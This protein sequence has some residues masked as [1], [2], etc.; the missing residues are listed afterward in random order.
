M[1]ELKIYG[2]LVNKKDGI[3]A[4]ANQIAFDD[5]EKLDVKFDELNGK[6]TTL[7]EKVDSIAGGTVDVDAINKNIDDLKSR[8]GVNESDIANL[9]KQNE[10]QE[11]KLDETSSKAD[12][13]ASKIASLQSADALL[14]SKMDSVT[15]NNQAAIDA[16]DSKI[17]KVEDS[18]LIL[19]K[20]S[21]NKANIDTLYDTGIY[22]LTNA[23]NSPSESADGVLTVTSTGEN[24]IKQLWDTKKLSAVRLGSIVT[25]ETEKQ[26]EFSVIENGSELKY[27]STNCE[28][29]LT[30]GKTYTLSGFL[31]GHIV[32]N[33]GSTAP[34]NSTK[35]ILNGVHIESDIESAIHYAVNSSRLILELPYGTTNYVS[36]YPDA[37]GS[38]TDYSATIY[39]ENN[40]TVEGAGSLI[41]RNNWSQSHGIKGSEV[42]IVL[43]PKVNPGLEISSNHDGIHG[44]SLVD[45]A[46]GNIYIHDVTN[47]GIE[48]QNSDSTKGDLRIRA[49]KIKIANAKFGIDG[50]ISCRVEGL[51]TSLE[52]SSVKEPV[53]EKYLSQAHILD[54][55]KITGA[56]LATE[57]KLTFFGEPKVWIGDSLGNKL[58]DITADSGIYS[59]VNAGEDG[60]VY[61][62]GYIKDCKIVCANK[63]ANLVLKNCYIENTTDST[64]ISY[65]NA[66]SRLAIKSIGNDD[67]TYVTNYIV[68]SSSE[69]VIT[70][71]NNGAINTHKPLFIKGAGQLFTASE[72]TIRGDGDKYF[73]GDDATA[74]H[75]QGTYVYIGADADDV[76]TGTAGNADQNIFG[77]KI[78]AR[79]SS[80]LEKGTIFTYSQ[81]KGNIYADEISGES[82]TAPFNLD[83]TPAG[84]I[85]VAENSSISYPDYYIQVSASMKDVDV[86]FPSKENVAKQ[87]TGDWT[88]LKDASEFPTTDSITELIKNNSIRSYPSIED[89][90]AEI[91]NLSVASIVAIKVDST[92]EY[93]TNYE[94]YIVVEDSDGNKVFK[95]LKGSGSDGGTTN[96]VTLTIDDLYIDGVRQN[97]S[98]A[99][100]EANI[101]SKIDIKYSFVSMYHDDVKG[102]VYFK[103]G[104]TLANQER[105]LPTDGQVNSW[106]YDTSGLTAGT[107]KFSIYGS[108]VTGTTSPRQTL[109]FEIGGLNIT[110][111]FNEENVLTAGNNIQ[112]PVSIT[113]ATPNAAITAHVLVDGSEVKTESVKTSTTSLLIPGSYITAGTHEIEI[114]LTNDKSKE[115]NHISY[116][117]IAANMG[118]IYVLSDK[119]VYSISAGSRLDVQIR[120]IQMGQEKGSFSAKMKITDVN[121]DLVELNGK[122][123]SSYTFNYGKNTLQI[124]GLPYKQNDSGSTDSD[125]T[126]YTIALTV[127]SEDPDA[128]AVTKS[129]EARV[130]QNDYNISASTD[131]LL[132]WFDAAGKSNKDDDKDTWLD[133]SGNGV[134]ATFGNFNW[135]SN[136]WLQDENGNTALTLNSG[137]YVELDITPFEDEPNELTISIDYETTDI[138][139]SSAKVVSCLRETASKD[140]VTYYLRDSWGDYVKNDTNVAGT[141]LDTSFNDLTVLEDRTGAIAFILSTITNA[142][143]K[144]AKKTELEGMT[145]DE[146]LEEY[147]TKKFSYVNNIL[148]Y[149]MFAGGYCWIDGK[150]YV[151]DGKTPYDV[152]YAQSE[153][154]INFNKGDDDSEYDADNGHYAKKTGKTSEDVT[155]QQGF[156]IDTQYGV[157]SNSSSKADAEDKFHM[158][159][160]QG[161]R[162]R[163]DFIITRNGAVKPYFLSCMAGYVNGVITGIQEIT[164]QDT[165]KQVDSKGKKYRVYLG[166]K[167]T[168]DDNGNLTVS[169]TGSCKIYSFRIYNKALDHSQILYNYAAE[170]PDYDEKVKV[171]DNNGLVNSTSLAHLPRLCLMGAKVNGRSTIRDF[172]MQLANSDESQIS[173]LKSMKEPAY[174]T[175]TDPDNTDNNWL[176]DDGTFVIPVRLQFQGTSSMVYPMKNYKFKMY[177]SM[178]ISSDG[179][180]TYGK[181]LKKD[182]VGAGINEST[183]TIKVNYM[184]S[185]NVRNTGSANFI[186][187]YN[188]ITG[189]TPAM[190]IDSRTRTT[191]YGYPILLYYKESPDSTDEEQFLGVGCLNLD[192]SD[193]D[194]FGLDK[195]IND[196]DNVEYDF[197]KAFFIDDDFSKDILT[198]KTKSDGT[199]ETISL[200]DSDEG[201]FKDYTALFNKDGLL[202]A[203]VSSK[204]YLRSVSNQKVSNTACF[205]LK[206]NSGAS[207][208]GGFGNYYIDSVASDVEPRY[209]DDGDIEDDE[210]TPYAQDIAKDLADRTLNKTS[211]SALTFKQ[212][213]SPYFYHFQR[214]IKW[215]RSAS[216]EE[217]VSNIDK[218]FNRNYLMDYYLT[219]LLLGGVDSLGKNLMVGTWGPENRLFLTNED[220]A[221]DPL[222]FDYTLA[223][224]TIIRIT[225]KKNKSTGAYAF[226]EDEN[227]RQLFYDE[228]CYSR[229][230]KQF[231]SGYSA[232]VVTTTP[233]ECIWYPMFYDIDTILGV[234]NSGQLLYD[235]DIELGDQ[236]EDGTMVFNTADSYLWTKVKNYLGDKDSSGNSL[237]SDRWS[238]LTNAGK[239]TYDNLVGKFYYKDIISKIPEYYYNADCFT[240][241]IHEGPDSTQVGSKSY[242]YCCHG[243][244]YEHIKKWV[245]ERIYYLNSMFGKV[246]TTNAS[247]RFNYGN[248][249]SA[250]NDSDSYY[251]SYA[252]LAAN[253]PDIYEYNV[254]P[255]TGTETL[256]S[257]LTGLEIKPIQFKFKT[258]QPGYVGIKWFNGGQIHYQRVERNGTATIQGNVKTSG[259]A[260]VFIYGGENI[261]EIGDMS[262]YNAKQVDFKYL[263]KLNKLELGSSDYS[264]VINKLD[265]GD[266]NTYL[267]E[268]KLVRCGSLSSVDVSKCINLKE[269]DMTDSGITSISLPP[270]GGALEKISYSNNITSIDLQNFVNLKSISAPALTNL[271]KFVIKNCPK[272]LGTKESPNST[273]WMLLQQTYNTSALTDIQVTTYGTVEPKA[274]SDTYSYFFPDKYYSYATAPYIRGEI[275]YTGKTIPANYTKFA[276]AFPYLT[277]TYNNIEDASE[278]FANYNNL[279]C[280][281][282]MSVYTGTDIYGNAQYRSV[283][284]WT[285]STAELQEKWHSQ[286]V[287][288]Q[289]GSSSSF[290]SI[291]KYYYKDGT[292]YRLLGIYDESDLDIIR[293]EIKE[294]LSNFT[295]FT[296]LTGLFRNMAILDYID[297]DTFNSIDISSAD[298][299]EMFSG[300][301]NLRY[302]EV[303]GDTVKNTK[304]IKYY[305]L[306]SDTGDYVE[307][308]RGEYDPENGKTEETGK[309]INPFTK[310][311]TDSA[312]SIYRKG[313]RTLGS[314]MFENCQKAAIYIHKYSG[315][316]VNIADDA[317]QYAIYDATNNSSNFTYG[318]PVILFEHGETEI[319]KTT[320]SATTTINE[321][322]Y[323]NI[324]VSGQDGLYFEVTADGERVFNAQNDVIN[325][326]N[327][328]WLREVYFGISGVTLDDDSK[329]ANIT[330]SYATRSDGKIIVLKADGV[331][332]SFNINSSKSYDNSNKIYSLAA[333]SLEG[334]SEVTEI[335]I[336]LPTYDSLDPTH[337]RMAAEI[338]IAN[339][340]TNEKYDMSKLSSALSTVTKLKS[341]FI[342]NTE[343]IP[344]FSFTALPQITK[345]GISNATKYIKSRAFSE[346]S[347]LTT[348]V[349]NE[350]S[351]TPKDIGSGKDQLIEIGD[352]AFSLSGLTSFEL[353]VSVSKL[354]IRAFSDCKQMLSFSFRDNTNITEVPEGMFIGDASMS[355]A[356]GLTSGLMKIGNDAFSGCSKLTLLYD[357]KDDS[358]NFT[359]SIALAR[360]PNGKNFDY[361]ENL[362]YIGN[363]A[364]LNVRDILDKSTAERTTLLKFPKSI[365]YIGDSAFA[366]KENI[367]VNGYTEFV[368]DGDYESDFK[369]LVIGPSAFSGIK[370]CWRIVSSSQPI[371]NCICIPKLLAI[372]DNAFKLPGSGQSFEY[373][374]SKN[375]KE[376]IGSTWVAS[377]KKTI[378]EY[379]GLFTVVDETADDYGFYYLLS[380]D[381]DADDGEAYA[382]KAYLQNLTRKA[383]AITVPAYTT[384]NGSKFKVVEILA[385]AFDICGNDLSTLTFDADSKLEL[386]EK[387]VLKSSSL[388]SIMTGNTNNVLPATLNIETGNNLHDTT[389]FDLLK[390]ESEY[391][392]KFI[393]LGKN[394]I[395]YIPADNF[396]GTIDLTDSS[397]AGCTT[398]FD[399]AF[400]GMSAVTSVI[401]TDDI[402]A[403]YSSAFSGTSLTELNLPS[404]IA[405]IDEKAFSGCKFEKLV[406]PASLTSIG[407]GAF[408][409]NDSKTTGAGVLRYVDIKDGAKISGSLFELQQDISMA[410]VPNANLPKLA[411]ISLREIHIPKT[412]P[413]LV[414]SSASQLKYMS[415]AT[416]MYLGT[417]KTADDGSY[418]V[419][420]K[421]LYVGSDGSATFEDTGTRLTNSD[422]KEVFC[423]LF[424]Y[425]MAQKT[426]GFKNSYIETTEQYSV[427]PEGDFVGNAVLYYIR[428]YDDAVYVGGT[429]PSDLNSGFTREDLLRLISGYSSDVNDDISTIEL[430]NKDYKLIQS[431]I[432]M[433]M[434]SGK[435]I[436]FQPVTF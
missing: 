389:W 256:S 308:D 430:S 255:E 48:A 39:S 285:D 434:Q 4:N 326:K 327:P 194:S 51:D 234:D 126:K 122:T 183:F 270:T 227:G 332:T 209:P 290:E 241:Y 374:L 154:T 203:A 337:S 264:C 56:T 36:A 237:L 21:L 339:I 58:S 381:T 62:E 277:I 205:E 293:A 364:F 305:N 333:G 310:E 169:D 302:F 69:T 63:K 435:R 78:H 252:A 175:Y 239:F 283:Y 424:Y 228:N 365:Q 350:K 428:G 214:L 222:A 12:A 96:T 220:S 433:I 106:S 19:P 235:V 181:K 133:K 371:L 68:S 102:T 38:N 400:K 168:Y 162:T 25:N 319:L 7:D 366:F 60:T 161:T 378:F 299:T 219:I 336:P 320:S 99:L 155:K 165:F 359:N 361:F 34:A 342:C 145:D 268:L 136:G 15:A 79:L 139:D 346:M 351:T 231:N 240:K 331:A 85:Y 159:F 124:I 395:G 81:Q 49:G 276:E 406:F 247:L 66:K 101:G 396:S 184:D 379:Y 273:A 404:K 248:Y 354:G 17:A 3:V 340:F 242:L 44:S 315:E 236:L 407:S 202:T 253:N 18:A 193:T 134:T 160:S 70:S 170:I 338:S 415:Q 422:G 405:R 425:N 385:G 377:T 416:K 23:V 324:P 238:V 390:N 152:T 370:A 368:W 328:T 28:V 272:I 171:I 195:A 185:S 37:M 87:V 383:S 95:Q 230:T 360:N 108:D 149:F 80:K 225:P 347:D 128:A 10:T 164:T 94:I 150:T 5:G 31:S 356:S 376:E 436:K 32:I 138:L 191:I 176:A 384:Y 199:Y 418:L 9:K 131:G 153:R 260:E 20:S 196:T 233:G 335:E 112:F 67:E 393:T 110:S 172:I 144:A 421:P 363:N 33:A 64:I 223:N 22:T 40:I 372:G 420:N 192:K 24:A 382:G 188:E 266:N 29:T 375:S 141:A 198:K 187:D 47:S 402:T 30:A 251:N 211:T 288:D 6:L 98:D 147:K 93:K 408:S 90:E 127:T 414:T 297:P 224:G 61:V 258:Y 163:M 86:E 279:N 267:A 201:A 352:S 13:N 75:I 54:T 206:A 132:C 287:I 179:T 295:K 271:N 186:A 197:G 113:T 115:S 307:V 394:I 43:S 77:G 1:A 208:A 341:I 146:V 355:S 306:D 104:A 280:I 212:Y 412:M 42:N 426:K 117:I 84:S 410:T 282:S 59:T 263:T 148:R 121:G 309:Y 178:D 45:I 254:D 391:I 107:Y 296:N 213:K 72:L 311:V 423:P 46:N 388:L 431:D 413:E 344:E 401:F 317:F 125:Y 221:T 312:T 284:Y 57:D 92:D 323:D 398:I 55:V 53:R 380:S 180:V 116:S 334:L 177:K 73:Y 330:L 387:N 322:E 189:N 130:S 27:T 204:G 167:G 89:A 373:A 349:F 109:N 358:G 137:A 76:S 249:D 118:V 343:K 417:L 303:P 289:Y 357:L 173:D 182:I 298:T 318:R 427:C 8:V 216:K 88:I 419:E 429:M 261:K 321:T 140:Y 409:E 100:F 250:F 210:Y 151:A 403:I 190:D 245:K 392:G 304:E 2:T 259:D 300:C 432:A 156:Y 362:Q 105:V 275:N 286:S 174:I 166:G 291:E 281:S 26:S 411:N 353:P 257:K 397:A 232:F 207:G 246:G 97:L 103:V 292:Y 316:K 143:E 142:T 399:D 91:S 16:L 229:V 11:T 123:E 65:T 135:S 345:I 83:Y 329:I 386:I 369:S 226:A 50:A 71:T 215:V 14:S 111:T 301:T 200:F 158:N 35:I 314:K 313:M 325:M 244:S 265:L 367:Q 52:F 114:Y 129:F 157:L 294:A 262:P 119:D 120:T 278:M 82:A 269:V 218:H 41:I 243:N 274:I 74:N 217:F 348:F